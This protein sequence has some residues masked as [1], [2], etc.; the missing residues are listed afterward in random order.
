M[1][2]WYGP[3][4]PGEGVKRCFSALN[5]GLAA[6]VI[7]VGA[8]E[9]RF[10]WAEHLLGNYLM[11]IN[12]SRPETGGIWEAGHQALSANKSLNQIIDKKQSTLRHVQKAE[13]FSSLAGRLGPG[14][15][16]NLDRRQFKGLFNTLPAGTRDRL[17]NPARLVW[18]LTTNVVDRIFCEGQMGLVT[19]Y[20]ID[21]DNRV[22][23]QFSLNHQD[24]DKTLDPSG[25]HSRLDDL[26]GV[27]SRILPADRFFNA[28]FQLPPDMVSELMGN[29]DRLLMQSGT[30][31][32]VGIGDTVEN[33]YI[34][35][36]FEFTDLDGP[37]VIQAQA[38]EW[39][40]WQLNLTL[41]G[42]AL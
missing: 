41:R 37:R 29:T 4:T 25:I 10:D 16:V 3:F 2:N 8:S 18:L 14:E 31:G 26:D 27:F 32:R 28:L 5:L 12:S 36:G 21:A 24:L 38:R 9:L 23:S 19:V 33:G 6:L 42:E 22:V 40:V 39:A 20:F 17:I 11:V 35:L 34:R 1:P 13:S 30:L 15:W 7:L